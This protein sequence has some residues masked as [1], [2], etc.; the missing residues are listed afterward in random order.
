ML[1]IGEK[2]KELRK[3][4][5]VTQEKLAEYLGVTAQAVSRWE[6]GICYPDVEIFPAIANFFNITLDELF[7]ADKKAEKLKQIKAEI[8]KKDVRGY[9][10]EAIKLCRNALK[11]FPNNYEIMSTLIGLLNAKE[12]QSEMIELCDRIL[13]DC[14]DN[15]IKLCTLRDLTG[16]YKNTG[17]YEKAK[18][19]TEK[20]PDISSGISL[21]KE[22][23]LARVLQGEEKLFQHRSVI[24][25]LMEYLGTEIHH[26]VTASRDL[27]GGDYKTGAKERIDML[28]RAVKF[29]ELIFSDKNYGFYNLRFKENYD[30]IAEEYIYLGDYDKA[31]EYIEK[32]SDYLIAF[33][34]DEGEYPHTSFLIRGYTNVAGFWHDSPETMSYKTIHEHYLKKE[35][36]APIREH[37][38]FKAVI[39]KLEPFAKSV[40]YN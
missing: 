8:Y 30:D 7:E 15:Y 39:K 13:T 27:C 23:W 26:L 25:W 38:K 16:I 29:Y 21:S 18:E 6:S 1:K 31:L 37:A 11:E 4:L 17:N 5:N 22:M 19:T 14:D 10:V 34:N 32:S 36:F 20:L 28:E 12:N 2:I 24:Y 35:I 3:K 33:E 40:Q 9:T